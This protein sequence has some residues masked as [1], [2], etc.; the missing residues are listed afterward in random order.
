MKATTSPSVKNNSTVPPLRRKTYVSPFH[1][2]SKH[3]PPNLPSRTAPRKVSP[4]FGS[5]SSQEGVELLSAEH[6]PAIVGR[7]E[8]GLVVAH[9][10]PLVPAGHTDAALVGLTTGGFPEVPLGE[11]RPSVGAHVK[12]P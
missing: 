6:E 9:L 5:Y 8:G 2:T 11:L 12:S 1:T 4:P 10:D 7:A 3:V